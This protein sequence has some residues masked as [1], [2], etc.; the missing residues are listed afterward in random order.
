MRGVYI[1]GFIF[2]LGLYYFIRSAIKDFDGKRLVKTGTK[3][4][5]TF[6]SVNRNEKYRM[7]EKNPWIIKC[8]WV[9]NNTNREYFF[10]SQDFFSDPTPYLNGRYHLDVY[11]DP[12]DPEKYFMDTSF[13]PEESSAIG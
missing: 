2:L 12:G 7:G 1:G 9:D 11:L 10:V 8:K 4:S 3:I 6:I 5:A 13:M